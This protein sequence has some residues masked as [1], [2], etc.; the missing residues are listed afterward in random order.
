GDPLD[1]VAVRTAMLCLSL[2]LPGDDPR[3]RR[4]AEVARWTGTGA[5]LRFDGPS[6][7]E[8]EAT[9]GSPDRYLAGQAIRSLLARD[10]GTESALLRLL[11]R[12]TP[13]DGLVALYF[14]THP[15]EG[16]VEPLLSALMRHPDK[17]R[18]ADLLVMALRACVP[19]A[20]RDALVAANGASPARWK[21]WARHRAEERRATL[22]PFSLLVSLLPLAVLIGL[23]SR[24]RPWPAAGP[25]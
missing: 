25:A 15:S 18:A 23:T 11:A 24:R 16:A 12:G 19:D 14:A 9:A 3:A 6:L 17:S 21:D 8:L 20:Q 1:R 7:H 5:G 22:D 13:H 4:L 10:D 2:E